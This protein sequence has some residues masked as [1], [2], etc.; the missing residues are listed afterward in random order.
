MSWLA[1]RS[2]PR[3]RSAHSTPHARYRGAPVAAWAS[4]SNPTQ[5]PSVHAPPGFA[6]QRPVVGSAAWGKPSGGTAA[7]ALTRAR[8]RAS[9]SWASSS[10]SMLDFGRLLLAPRRQRAV[11]RR[12]PARVYASTTFRMCVAT[13][14]TS[15][16]WFVTVTLA[17]DF[18]AASSRSTIS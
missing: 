3:S 17:N 7:V 8:S 16:R 15:S 9:A 13:A 5:K 4:Q 12:A 1:W 14:T 10:V 18:R 11:S 6:S 2:R